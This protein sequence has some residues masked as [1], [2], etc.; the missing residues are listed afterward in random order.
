MNASNIKISTRL[1]MTFAILLTLM[2]S[3][4]GLT[5][6][7]LSSVKEQTANIT[8][9]RLPSTQQLAEL[10]RLTL[11]LRLNELKY[12]YD[13]S[14]A[15]KQGLEKDMQGM[16]GRFDAILD[17]YKKGLEPGTQALGDRL[18]RV[19]TDINMLHNQVVVLSHQG[20]A[21]EVD[22]LLLTKGAE[23]RAQI[24][25]VLNELNE[26]EV[27]WTVEATK[28]TRHDF[29]LSFLMLWVGC[30]VALVFAA[31]AAWWLIRYLL[32]AFRGAIAAAR[33]IAD[34]NLIE[35]V[36]G[37][38]LTNEVGQ[39]LSAM[40]DMRA[41][42][43]DTVATVRQNADGV[44]SGSEQIARGNADLSSRTEQ[45]AAALEETASAMEELSATIKQNTDNAINADRLAQDAS[46]VAND[47]GDIVKRVVIRMQDINEGANRVVEV[48]SLLESIAF[49]TN[50]L[51]L[52]ASVEAARAGEQGRGFA[53]VASEVRNLAQ[54]S[55]EASREIG[56]L[57]T[58]S[59]NSIRAGTELANEAGNT[60]E[61]VVASVSRLKNI[62]GEISAA[63]YEQNQGVTQVGTA[64][65]QMDQ[66]TQQNAALV[67]ESAAAAS[68]LYEQ[69]R[70][71]Q[72]T[73]QVFQVR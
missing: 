11:N 41:S 72:Q 29:E 43:A 42:L 65:T 70:T 61:G 58:E 4:A 30:L 3:L 62:M 45:Q 52:N 55:A 24:E 19:W 44:A 46:R 33:R 49:Q 21:V 15:E 27:K 8:N 14:A 50:L 67:E 25:T 17:Q 1:I 36:Q 68:S 38:E 31:M 5:I 48:I 63:S 20:K 64:V 35:E 66:T 37:R 40:D 13:L 51:A 73:V 2:I 22:Q 23:Q 71:L 12:T 53:V 57:I 54:R 7:R 56:A 60:M 9:H 32:E 59:V 10:R 47:G 39:L 6:V 34:G 18:D 28:S 26:R 69:A 16:I